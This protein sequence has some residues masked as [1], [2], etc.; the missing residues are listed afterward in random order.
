MKEEIVTAFCILMYLAIMKSSRSGTCLGKP[1]HYKAIYHLRSYF[2]V[3]NSFALS[4]LCIY[5]SDTTP[6]AD[7]RGGGDLGCP[8]LVQISFIFMQLS[9]KS[10]P[11]K[12]LTHPAWEIQD[13][14]LHSTYHLWFTPRFSCNF[15][16]PPKAGYIVENTNCCPIGYHIDFKKT[17]TPM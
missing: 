2:Q 3:Y 11:R 7:P 5:R 15:K 1:L 12:R 6:L 4:H 14:S 10:L 16:R 13:L 8:L 9:A 17:I